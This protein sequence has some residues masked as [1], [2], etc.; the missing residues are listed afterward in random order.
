MSN[1]VISILY[2]ALLTILTGVAAYLGKEIVKIVPKIIE[3]VVAKIGLT[4]YQKTKAIAWDIWNIVEEQFRLNSIIGD[5]VQAKVTMFETLIKQKIPGITDAEI[6]AF[7]QAI[8]GEFN[9]DKPAVIKE[10]TDVENQA[11]QQVVVEPK[12]TT[13]YIAPDGT[14][15]IPAEDKPT[16]DTYSPIAGTDPGTDATNSNVNTTT[17]PAENVQA[18]AA[19]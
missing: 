7:R 4:N 10:I 16:T 8:A 11:K 6:E 5:T 12:I 9:K 18:P 3:F 19:Q 1:Q 2:P 15:L 13:E 14:K 17:A